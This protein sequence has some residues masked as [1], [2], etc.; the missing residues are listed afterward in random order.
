MFQEE[1]RITNAPAK[2]AIDLIANVMFVETD[3]R[4]RKKENKK[5]GQNLQSQHLILLGSMFAIS[6]FQTSFRKSKNPRNQK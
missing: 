6:T 3:S 4:K 1:A 5:I 2:Q